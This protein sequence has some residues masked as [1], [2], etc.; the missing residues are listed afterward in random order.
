MKTLFI[1]FLLCSSGFLKAQSL[2]Y[3]DPAAAYNRLIL[4]KNSGI[5]VQ[6]G[7]YKVQGTKYLYGGKLETDVYIKT[8][9]LA[10]QVLASYDT[11]AKN[12]DVFAVN[13]D[14]KINF[15][16]VDSF[17][18]NTKT[19]EKLKFVAATY[20]DPSKKG[21]FQVV[22]SNSN[23]ILYKYYDSQLTIPTNNYVDASLRE[24]GLEYNYYFYDTKLKN[25]KKMNN[26]NYKY[27]TKLLK[28]NITEAYIANREDYVLN[29]ETSLIK[30]F[31]NYK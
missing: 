13:T 2:S 17:I 19:G 24:F 28:N 8:R 29:I 18:S 26:T 30:M 12:L 9:L 14:N 6:V 3:T 25:L 4:E 20:V 16:N 1:L 31:E 27:V 22:T 11:Y 21:F 15:D 10:E 23:V 7:T 5:Y